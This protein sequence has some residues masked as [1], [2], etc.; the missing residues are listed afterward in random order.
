MAYV[1]HVRHADSLKDAENIASLIEICRN[2]RSTILDRFTTDQEKEFLENLPSKM[3][4]FVAYINGKFAGFASIGSRFSSKRLQ[5]CGSNGTWVKP[6][7]RRSGV[8]KK[9]WLEGVLPWSHNV[10]FRHLGF[11]VMS[12]NRNA[13]AFYESLGFKVIGCHQRLVNWEGQFLDAIEMEMWL[14]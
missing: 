10:G 13:I 14:D 3:A 12:H 4:V 9:L 11:F 7:F 6:S 1:I 2:E 5:H 8:G